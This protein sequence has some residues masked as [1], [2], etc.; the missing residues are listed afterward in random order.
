MSA[1]KSKFNVQKQTPEQE[2]QT[3]VGPAGIKKQAKG[4]VALKVK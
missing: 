3:C 2:I 4:A 1:G